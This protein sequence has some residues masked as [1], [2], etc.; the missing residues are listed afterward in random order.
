MTRPNVGLINEILLRHGVEYIL[1]GG[2]GCNAY[3][4]SRV[5]EDMDSVIKRSK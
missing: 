3:G 5:T 1:V 4:A 2:I